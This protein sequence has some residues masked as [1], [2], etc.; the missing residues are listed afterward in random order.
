MTYIARQITFDGLVQ[1]VGFRFTALNIAS[2]CRLTG[3]VCN[4]PDGTVKMIAQGQ[5]QDIEDCLQ[6]I[7][8]EFSEYI[9]DTKIEEISYDPKYKNF[10]IT[11]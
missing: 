3:S 8:E 5:Q 11:F 2:R 7:K 6:D 4:M 1:G 10:K 9:K